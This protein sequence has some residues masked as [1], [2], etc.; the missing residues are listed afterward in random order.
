ML[1]NPELSNFMMDIR[2]EKLTEPSTMSSS[3]QFFAV[4]ALLTP[5]ALFAATHHRYECPSPLID[6]K[7]KRSISHRRFCW[8][9]KED[10]VA[11]ACID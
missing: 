3:R 7:V 4:L 1:R 6:G 10:G 8:S 5:A 2:G 11:H 9:S